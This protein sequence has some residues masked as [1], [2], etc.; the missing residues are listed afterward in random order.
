[1]R[2]TWDSG[3]ETWIVFYGSC[4]KKYRAFE[5]LLASLPLPAPRA[6]SSAQQGSP[7]TRPRHGGVMSQPQ[8]TD[9]D[10]STVGPVGRAWRDALR[11]RQRQPC[12]SATHPLAAVGRAGLA[13]STQPQKALSKPFC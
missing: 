5:V 11:R 12:T 7:S 2:A 4:E 6:T 8:E 13:G 3:A 9:P 10:Q 1:M